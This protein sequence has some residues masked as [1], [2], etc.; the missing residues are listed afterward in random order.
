VNKVKFLLIPLIVTFLVTTQFVMV[1]AAP[2]LDEADSISGTLYSITPITDTST[3]V[4]IYELTVIDDMGT[5]QTVRVSQ[6]TAYGLG[7]LDYD[8]D[9]NLAAITPEFWPDSISIPLADTIPTEEEVHHP[10]GNALATFFSNIPG[11]DYDVIMTA[12]EDGYGFGV[13]AQALWLTQKME[14]DTDIL[15]AILEAKKT[16]DFSAFTLEDGTVPTNWGQF[17]KAIM[18]GDKKNNLGVVMA[19]KE[20]DN[21]DA[22]NNG[23]GDTAGNANNNGN[24]DKNKDK[25]N[26]GNNGSNGNN[27]D[28]GNNGNNGN[29]PNKDNNGK[30]K[31]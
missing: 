1:A 21:G 27:P 3:G 14:G 11:V 28:K 4:T 18:N 5:H 23:N 2:S 22:G 7:L 13:I 12:H 24:Q 6:E 16:G 19:N 10:V 26:N 25:G 9:G 15:T 31:P 8:V 17:R 29:N 20:K 30:N